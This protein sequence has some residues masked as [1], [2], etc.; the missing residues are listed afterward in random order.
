DRAAQVR[1]NLPHESVPG[2]VFDRA[3]NV[4]SNL[5]RLVNVPA[6]RLDCRVGVADEPGLAVGDDLGGETRSTGDGDDVAHH[7]LDQRYRAALDPARRDEDVE[8]IVKG[9]V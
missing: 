3:T 6:N 9:R 4:G 7:R 8:L 5:V 1:R 2:Q